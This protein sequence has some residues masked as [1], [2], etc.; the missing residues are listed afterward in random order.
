MATQRFF[1]GGMAGGLWGYVVRGD[2]QAEFLY[3]ARASVDSVWK[4][5]RKRGW[6]RGV[7]GG[8]VGVFV[9]GLMVINVVYERDAR[10]VSAGMV[11]R[12]ISGLRGEGLGDIVKEEDARI[13][14]LK[15][16]GRL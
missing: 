12:G 16:E 11:R 9:L 15:E 10:A 4:V 3:G 7:R 13:K 2:A 14:R 5:G 6:W 1:L 8:D